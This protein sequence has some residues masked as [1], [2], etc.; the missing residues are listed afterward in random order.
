MVFDWRP[1][2]LGHAIEQVA[3]NIQF[4]EGLSQK[5]SDRIFKSLERAAEGQGAVNT[6]VIQGATIVNGALTPAPAGVSVSILP[7]DLPAFAGSDFNEQI[8][9]LPVGL[10]V[11]SAVYS[12]WEAMRQR[13]RHWLTEPL[14]ICL[15]FTGVQAIRLEYQDR[16]IWT[17]AAGAIQAAQVIRRDTPLVAPHVFDRGDAWHSHTGHFIEGRTVPSVEQLHIGIQD[18]PQQAGTRSMSIMSAREDRVGGK[19]ELTAED[20]FEIADSMHDDLSR[21]IRQVLTEEALESINMKA[22][23]S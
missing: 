21:L 8:E 19:A 14:A 11:R 9:A 15:E 22:L 20:V 5:V 13:L 10:S 23:Q 2:Q 18:T 1:R 17:G 12:D 3:F 7:G 4:T 6:Q 16:F